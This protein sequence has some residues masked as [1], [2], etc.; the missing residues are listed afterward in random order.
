LSRSLVAV[1]REFNFP[2]DISAAKHLE[3]T[4][5]PA[6]VKSYAKDLAVLLEASRKIAKVL[7]E[8]QR[9]WQCELVNSRC[10]DPKVWNI[11]DIVFAR[12]QTRSD[13]G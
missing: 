13:K 11:G 3:L 7:L 1:G 2:I 9:T 6:S 5:T 10:P 8:E 4:S 12:R